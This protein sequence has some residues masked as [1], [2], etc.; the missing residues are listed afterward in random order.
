MLAALR[1]ALPDNGS[2]AMEY[3]PMYELPRVGRVDAGTVELIRSLG[4][5]VVSS[6]DII[7]HATERWSDKQLASHLSAVDSLHRIVNEAFEFIGENVRWKLTEHDVAEFIRGRFDRAGLITADGPVVAFEE[8]SSDPHYEPAPGSS[9]VIRRNGWLL[10][11]LWAR[12][13]EGDSIY[14][15]ITWTAHI[16]GPPTPIQQEVFGVVAKARDT[17]FRF[18]EDAVLEGRYPEGWEVDDAARRVISEAGYGDYFVHRL[19]HSLGREV[20]AN[21]VNLDG[22]ETKDTRRLIEGLGV[23]IEP[24]IYL[25]EFGVR[26]EI[27]IFMA[28]DGPVITGEVQQEVIVIDTA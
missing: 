19:G 10:I 12:V 4:P 7:Q 27:D 1:Q 17:G 6:G 24:G 5:E 15:D 20:H 23:T 11:D 3:S 9:A 8:H 28:E 26:S 16:G 21:G 18:L 2:V 14:A 13:D 25:P 22:W